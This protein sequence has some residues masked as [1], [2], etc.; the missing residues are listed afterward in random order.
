[1]IRLEPHEWSFLNW[2]GFPSNLVRIKTPMDGSCFFH[3]IAKACME[4]YQTQSYGGKHIN[5][6]EF[7]RRFRKTLSQTLNAP[8]CPYHPSIRQYHILSRGQLP[9]FSKSVPQYSLSNMMDELDSHAPVDHAYNEF[10]SNLIKKDIYLLDAQ[11]GDVYITGDDRDILYKDRDSIVL[12]VIPGHYEL[13]GLLV[14][15]NTIQTV[16]PPH[17]P[18]IQNI[19]QRIDDKI[20][21]R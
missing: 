16:F 7:I 13:V 1:M 19:S 6:G 15:E 21:D 8:V 10:I 2:R 4:P 17:H 3:A 11:R 9:E 12:L 5:R 18:L 20:K 14:G